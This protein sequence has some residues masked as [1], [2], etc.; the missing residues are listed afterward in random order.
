VAEDGAV[1]GAGTGAGAGEG[2]GAEGASPSRPTISTHVLDTGSGRPASGVHVT[3]YRLADDARPVRLTQ[4]LTDDDGRVNDLLDR[5]LAA[6]TYRLEVRLGDRGAFFEG[7]AIDFRVEA[8]DRSYHVPLLLSPYS[9][10]TYRG[11]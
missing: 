5:P 4:A 7:A 11:S 1:T 3:L 8:V 2:A 6:G 9:L 10:T